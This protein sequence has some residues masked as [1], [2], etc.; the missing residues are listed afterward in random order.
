MRWRWSQ[1][2]LLVAPLW[3]KKLQ[4]RL[5]LASQFLLWI[6]KC[7]YFY[8]FLS[9]FLPFLCQWYFKKYKTQIFERD[10]NIR[11]YEQCYFFIVWIVELLHVIEKHK[12]VVNF[13]FKI[14]QMTFIADSLAKIKK[15]NDHES[16]FLY[17]FGWQMS[18]R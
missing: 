12:N 5:G 14:F 10:K 11:R 18:L 1:S 9:T 13:H 4:R 16:F 17:L 6:I 15:R 2:L 8:I 3:S 7:N